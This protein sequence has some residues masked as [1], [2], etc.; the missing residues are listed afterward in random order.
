MLWTKKAVIASIRVKGENASEE[1]EMCCLAGWPKTVLGNAN[2]HAFS[3]VSQCS[4][5]EA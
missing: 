4:W 3:I 2:W 1:G 5:R